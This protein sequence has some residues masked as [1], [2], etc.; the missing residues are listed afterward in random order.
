M[1][2]NRRSLWLCI[3]ILTG[4]QANTDSLPDYI[5]DATRRAHKE[6]IPLPAGHSFIASIYSQSQSED[7][8]SLPVEAVVQNQPEA[9]ND[10]WQPAS[11]A[12][13]SSLERFSLHQLTFKGVIGSGSQVSALIAT[14]EGRLTYVSRGQYIGS[15]H[16]RVVTIRDQYVLVKETLPDGLGCWTQRSVKLTLQ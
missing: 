16:G 5:T 1:I 7:P 3:L 13:K 11:Q 2:G 6:V 14:P 12:K 10:C 4:C 15:N 9:T 8:F